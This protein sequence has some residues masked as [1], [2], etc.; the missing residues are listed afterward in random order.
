MITISNYIEFLYS[1]KNMDKLDYVLLELSLHNKSFNHDFEVDSEEFV[2]RD[3]NT[4]VS[5][6]HKIYKNIFSH[7][8]KFLDKYKDLG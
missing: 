6:L 8:P 5:E 3:E 2:W 1:I 4:T 7:N